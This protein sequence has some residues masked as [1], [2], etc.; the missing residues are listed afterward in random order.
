MSAHIQRL[1]D[2]TGCG[3][4]DELQVGPPLLLPLCLPVSI[5]AAFRP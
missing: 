5:A 3:T 4:A 1:L 2:A